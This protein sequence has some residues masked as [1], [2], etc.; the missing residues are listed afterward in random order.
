MNRIGSDHIETFLG[1]QYVVPRIVIHYTGA[2]VADHIVI[3]AV[4]ISRRGFWNQRLD[5]A[6]CDFLYRR[7]RDKRARRHAR[8]ASHHERRTRALVEESG[9]MPEHSLQT[10]VLLLA[11]RFHFSAHMEQP[12]FVYLR[13][14]DG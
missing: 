10:H 13:D 1:G 6:Q 14:G 12:L 7:M 8:A 4:E 3:F 9:N 11:R 5:L 2:S